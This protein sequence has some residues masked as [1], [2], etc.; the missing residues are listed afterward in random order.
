MFVEATA[1]SGFTTFTYAGVLLGPAAVG[2]A[3]EPGGLTWTLAS[4]IPVLA[5]VALVTRL[6]TARR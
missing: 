5:T 1:V 4:P 3:A 2:W 6:P